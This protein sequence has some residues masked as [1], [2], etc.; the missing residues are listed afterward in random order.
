MLLGL[1]ILINILIP[2]IYYGGIGTTELEEETHY[3]KGL[4]YTPVTNITS[5]IME[6]VA[7]DMRKC[8]NLNVCLQT[9]SSSSSSSSV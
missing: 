6:E 2:H 9:C 1:L 7:Q 5:H 8:E 4:G 3:F